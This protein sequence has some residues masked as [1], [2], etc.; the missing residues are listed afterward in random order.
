[1]AY[2]PK[3]WACDDTITADD[4]NH[5]EQGIAENSGGST[6]PLIVEVVSQREATTE[7]CD[8][9]GVMYAYNHT[10][11]EVKDA[12]DAGT[13]VYLQQEAFETGSYT[14][15]SLARIQTDPSSASVLFIVYDRNMDTVTTVDLSAETPTEPL[16]QLV[17]TQK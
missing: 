14:R 6:A 15:G 3:T 10:W 12:Y 2:T 9:E 11:Q 16:M 4:L 8:E 13:P 5:I 7:E 1:M 17:C